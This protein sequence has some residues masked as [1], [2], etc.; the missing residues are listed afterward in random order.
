[1]ISYEEALEIAKQRKEH[2]DNCTEFENGF[3]F[4]FSGD[5]DYIGGYGH[6]PIV[7][8]KEDGRLSTMPEFISDGT[9]EEIRSFDIWN[10]WNRVF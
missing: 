5:N 1:M 7:I 9:G 6:A 8:M 2:I 3:V 4:G 10:V